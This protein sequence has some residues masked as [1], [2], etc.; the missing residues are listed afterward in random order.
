MRPS[1]SVVRAMAFRV[2]LIRITAASLPG[3][4]TVLVSTWWSYW[5]HTQRLEATSGDES[6]ARRGVVG[7]GGGAVGGGGRLEV[8]GSRFEVR[9][10]A[11]FRSPLALVGTR[12]GT[13]GRRERSYD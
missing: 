5:R 3:P 7:G 13:S 6:S 8:R 11:T 9:V 10:A 12:A 1:P 4:T 2:P